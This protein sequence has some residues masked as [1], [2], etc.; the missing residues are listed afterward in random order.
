M[1]A[2]RAN[3]AMLVPS[4][5]LAFTPM[6][7]SPPDHEALHPVA[8]SDV[9]A[10]APSRGAHGADLVDPAVRHRLARTPGDEHATRWGG[11]LGELSLHR[12][13]SARLLVV[14]G[15]DLAVVSRVALSVEDRLERPP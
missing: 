3:A 9:E 13:S 1:T 15:Q 8:D 11:V 7:A 12:C 6:T 5:V 4:T 2:L 10:V 14:K